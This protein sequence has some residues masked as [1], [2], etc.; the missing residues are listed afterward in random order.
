MQAALQS[1]DADFFGRC[2]TPMNT[3][4]N[5]DANLW[6][7]HFQK[8]LGTPPRPLAAFFHIGLRGPHSVV[9]AEEIVEAMELSGLLRHARLY[10]GV[11]GNLSLLPRLPRG[12]EV[13]HRGGGLEQFEF[14]TLRAL[15]AYSRAHPRA[16]VLYL[17]NKG[18][19]SAVQ[20]SFGNSGRLSYR[21]VMTNAEWAQGC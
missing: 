11:V 1:L 7:P 16:W 21:H 18:M 20:S 4:E 6:E 9:C 17:H 10:V 13:V 12:A 19:L 2:D 5:A 15:L 3:S 14:P 8:S